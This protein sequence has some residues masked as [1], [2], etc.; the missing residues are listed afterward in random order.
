MSLQKA[1]DSATGKTSKRH[2]QNTAA[3]EPAA[4]QT[5]IEK[6]D[7]LAG[8]VGEKRSELEGVRTGEAPTMTAERIDRE[9]VQNVTGG[10]ADASQQEQFRGEQM[11]LA[12][13]L[14]A[15]SRGE[16]PSVAGMQLKQ[17]T[18]R[19]LAQQL[20]M[21][22]GA[23]GAQ[24]AAARRQSASQV[25]DLGQQ[26]AGQSAILRLQEQQAAQQQLAGVTAQGRQADISLATADA[27]RDLRAN[28]ANQGVDLDVL[29]ANAAAGNAAA[30]ANLAAELSKMGMDD[31]MIQSY[32]A[33][34][35]GL[36]T[37]QQQALTAQQQTA[38]TA[39]ASEAAQKSSVL[40]GLMSAGG[41][42]GGAAIM[43]SDENVKMKIRPLTEEDQKKENK[44]EAQAT[45]NKK[46]LAEA[47]KGLGKAGQTK[48]LGS[49]IASAGDS[50]AKAMMSKA[51]DS[52]A[53]SD[54]DVKEGVK[55]AGNKLDEVMDNLSA[56]EYEYIDDKYGDAGKH[57]SVMAQDLQKSEIGSRAVS[58]AEDGSLQV[59]YAKL[60][61]AILAESVQN[62]KKVTKLEEALKARKGK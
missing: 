50:I 28:L 19:N 42:L 55:P 16:G 61:P 21:Q 20:A 39:R 13:R 3:R 33:A 45:K 15:Q 25:G 10:P 27:D 51:N 14:A 43:A 46:S 47:L 40:G 30:Q 9:G 35:T 44:V 31:A 54:E 59:D 38:A 17:A 11:S 49:G 22:A 37:G 2:A 29:K 60:L 34:E 57:V 36:L 53:T 7:A 4:V 12:Q 62:R 26:A 58:E 41:A 24:A 32:L 5:Q 48:D 56:S 23:S 1:W 8:E 6:S 52:K 18:D